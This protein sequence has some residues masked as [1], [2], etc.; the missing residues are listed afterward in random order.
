MVIRLFRPG[1]HPDCPGVGRIKKLPIGT[2]ENGAVYVHAATFFAVMALFKIG[3]A[4]EAAATTK[5]P[6]IHT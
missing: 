4:K 1:F 5:T 2:A 6:S 3:K